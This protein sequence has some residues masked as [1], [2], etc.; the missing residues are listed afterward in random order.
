MVVLGSGEGSEP[1]GPASGSEE[2]PTQRR[3]AQLEALEALLQTAVAA[4]QLLLLLLQP[5]LQ[6][7]VLLSQR[8]V[9]DQRSLLALLDLLH[10]HR[11][12]SESVSQPGSQ[13][14]RFLTSRK[15][16]SAHHKQPVST[17]S[18]RTIHSEH[19]SNRFSVC[20]GRSL[21]VGFGARQLCDEY[22]IVITGSSG[23]DSPSYWMGL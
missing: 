17:T 10:L 9:A 14:G 2:L 18:G 22:R 11:Q 16:K 12:D 8:P 6:L 19:S 13:P 5:R 3:L 23:L 7:Q 4:G 15:T 20:W 1:A 21:S